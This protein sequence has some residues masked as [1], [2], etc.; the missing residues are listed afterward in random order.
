MRVTEPDLA[1]STST[2]GPLVRAGLS[3]SPVL[4]QQRGGFQTF[5]IISCSHSPHTGWH[6]RSIKIA[7]RLLVF[8]TIHLPWEPP[9]CWSTPGIVHSSPST[10]AI[11]HFQNIKLTAQFQSYYMKSVPTRTHHEGQ[12]KKLRFH[13]LVTF[14]LP[15]SVHGGQI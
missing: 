7:K 9:S 4:P 5:L 3:T 12:Y 11:V 2:Q 8:P 13:L 1:L 10:S 14:P 15:V 6:K